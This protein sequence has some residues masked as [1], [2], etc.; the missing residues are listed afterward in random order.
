[1][2]RI[3]LVND[4]KVSCVAATSFP[5]GI[6]AAHEKLHAILPF[7]GGRKFFGISRPE[8]GTI[9]YKAG[10]DEIEEN[11]AAQFKLE[12]FIIKKGT[13][14]SITV[15]DYQKNLSKIRKTFDKLISKPGIDP[16]GYCIESY[17]SDTSVRC[18]VRLKG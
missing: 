15:K 11:E 17:I 8:N 9:V 4:I 14:I 13:Y 3:K 18:M 16:D 10:A 12:S 1:M 5:D 6:A 7:E 2:Q